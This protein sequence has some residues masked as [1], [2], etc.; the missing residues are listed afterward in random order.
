MEYEEVK[1]YIDKVKDSEKFKKLAEF[2]HMTT[3]KPNLDI[4]EN[5]K[6]YLGMYHARHDCKEFFQPDYDHFINF[7]EH[8]LND[9]PTEKVLNKRGFSKTS[10]VL[11]K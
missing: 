4:Y 6:Y 3:M 8:Y 2:T 11:W 10:Y 5:I 9:K 7:L 1:D